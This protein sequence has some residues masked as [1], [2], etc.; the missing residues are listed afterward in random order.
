MAEKLSYAGER[1][2]KG[3]INLNLLPIFTLFNKPFVTLIAPLR[4]G[5]KV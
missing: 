3:N 4:F 1:I 5:N 2:Y